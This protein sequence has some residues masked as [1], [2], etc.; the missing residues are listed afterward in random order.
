MKGNDPMTSNSGQATN[1]DAG[2]EALIRELMGSGSHPKAASQ[3]RDAVPPALAEALTAT[4]FQ[5]SAYEKALLV[6]VLAP[7]LAEALAPTLA[8]ALAPALVTALS[9]MAAA[10]KS[11]QQEHSGNGSDRPEGS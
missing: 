6:A 11:D 2:Y 1:Q 9:N 7:A 5:A 8:E 10:K 3:S 4:L